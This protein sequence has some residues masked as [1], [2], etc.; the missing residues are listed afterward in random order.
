MMKL[1]YLSG[2]ILSAGLTAFLSSCMTDDVETAVGHGLTMEVSIANTQ[3]SSSTRAAD[4]TASDGT[5]NEDQLKT[6][7]VYIFNQDGTSRLFYGHYDAVTPGNKVT[8]DSDPSWR[9]QFSSSGRYQVYALANYTGGGLSAI[10]TVT[11]LKAL[12][13]TDQD[14]YKLYAAG[15]AAGSSEYSSDKTFLMDGEADWTPSTPVSEDETVNISLKRAAAKIKVSVSL[16]PDM[17]QAYSLQSNACTWK[18]VNYTDNTAAIDGGDA[19]VPEEKTTGTLRSGQFAAD[20]TGSITTYTYADDWS[21][22]S[23]DHAPSLLVNLPVTDKTSGKAYDGNYYR[24]PLQPV[25][26]TKT[27]RNYI[28]M[29]NASIGTLGSSTELTDK[30]FGPVNYSVIPWTVDD[31]DVNADKINYLTVSPVDVVMQYLTTD[32]EVRYY[33]SSDV[34]VSID[35]VYYYDAD[36]NKQTIPSSQYGN[37]GLSVTPSADLKK[38]TVTIKSDLPDNKGIRYIKFTISNADGKS[39]QVYVRQ[40]PLEYIQFI[41][42]WYSTKTDNNWVDWQTDQTPH[43]QKRICND[44]H[45]EAK[46]YDNG[47]YPITESSSWGGYTAQKGRW[48]GYLDNRCMYVIEVT[49]TSDTYTISHPRMDSHG[50]SQDNVVSPAFMIASQLGA[51]T[52]FGNDGEA[53]ATHCQVYREVDTSGKKY[54]GW[55]LPTAEELGIIKEYQTGNNT[56]MKPVLTGSNYFAADGTAPVIFPHGDLGNYVRCVRDLTPEEVKALDADKK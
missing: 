22:Q 1:R 5:L 44:S 28:Y 6:L 4:G 31:I 38:G 8:L 13:Q 29:I 17:L 26:V 14:I 34:T 45:F 46:V 10:S 12:S 48:Y 56:V 19:V 42:G 41:D 33:S 23:S 18:F 50:L 25:K 49:S 54:D 40:Y 21:S 37:Y 53:A 43:S 24:I 36:G 32:T 51:V 7:D 30:D 2:V 47:I 9:N 35:E 55:R 39:Q 16:T 15:S 52:S 27:D 3:V 11:G 20:G